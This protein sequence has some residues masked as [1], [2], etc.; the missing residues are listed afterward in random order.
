MVFLL[1]GPPSELKHVL[2]E[3]VRPVL[4]QQLENVARRPERIFQVC[5]GESDIADAV[6]PVTAGL[7]VDVAYCASERSVEVRLTMDD[8]A[9]LD[10]VAEAVRGALGRNIFAEG[11]FLLEEVIV[12]TLTERGKTL[13]TAESCTGGLL[14]SRITDVSGSSA[15]FVGGVVCYANRIKIDMLNVDEAVIETQGAVCEE[16]ARQ[17]AQGV[18]EHFGTDYGIGI[19]G[20][21]GPGGGTAEKPVGL[22]YIAV[23]DAEGGDV[24][25]NAFGNDRLRNKKLYT[26]VALNML[27]LR[28]PV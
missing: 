18:R 21:A 8:A 5:M 16:V 1:P 23:A 3:R 19:T 10:Q 15:C 26:Q 25:R 11:R 20:I 2:Y 6:V 4:E 22:A 7:P 14:A 28:M 17:M 27:R 24:S 12:K 13:A 9:Q